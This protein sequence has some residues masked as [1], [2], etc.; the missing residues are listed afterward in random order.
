MSIVVAFLIFSFIV[1]I[2]ELGHF[3]FARRAGI[4]VEEFAIGMGPKL[5]GFTKNHC[6][7]TIRLL[8]IGGFCKMVGEDG[9][10]DVV[11]DKDKARK[12]GENEEITKEDL[13]VEDAEEDIQTPKKIL[14]GEP[15]YT[16]SVKE[17]ILAVFG[18]P[19]FNFILA[20][21]FSFIYVALSPISTTTIGYAPEEL[22]AYQSGI[23]EGDKLVSIDGHKVIA[24]F[25]ARIYINVA[26]GEPVDIEVKRTLDDGTVVP[27]GFTI[28]P[29]AIVIDAE[30]PEAEQEFF[31]RI[32]IGYTQV[33]TN[34]WNI[35]VYGVKECISWIKVVFYS[36]GMLLTNQVSMNQLS[37]PVAIVS[38]ISSE[39]ENSLAD[40]FVA[41]ISNISFFIVLLSSNLGVMNLLPIPALDGGRLVFLIIEGVRGKPVAP[42]KEGFVHLVGFALLMILMVFVLINDIGKVF[43]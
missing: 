35:I 20:L 5:F 19:L 41:V 7:W 11:S 40:G 1:F 24:P 21:F 8:P 14:N 9:E 38:E 32:G 17:R 13:V 30:V 27:L 6:E 33:E 42:E 29:E 36:L 34:L 23:R 18:G 4:A 22:P 37:G 10:D 31:Y 3:F 28:M 39:Y 12:K 2:H 16:R 26:G 43:G 25:E 15:F